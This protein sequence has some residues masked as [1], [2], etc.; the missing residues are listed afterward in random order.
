M[1]IDDDELNNYIC[2]K[3][4]KYTGY[5]EKIKDYTD[6]TKALKDLRYLIEHKPEELPEIIF[7][8][9][10]MPIMD[11]WEFLEEY[12]KL[13]KSYTSNI[14]LTILTTSIFE[15]DKE[16]ALTFPDVN[17]YLCKPLSADNLEII[18]KEMHVIA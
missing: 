3:I 9:L 17:N 11:G 14:Y 2:G 15:S 10:S 5:A 12:D 13:D 6:A 8:D 1:I 18:N 16:R 7:L 4:V